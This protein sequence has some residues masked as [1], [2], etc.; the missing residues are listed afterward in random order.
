MRRLSLLAACLC[1]LTD[2]ASA[3]IQTW[4]VGDQAHPWILRVVTGR[5]DWGKPWAVE[6]L[7]DDDGD[8]LIDEDPVE[9]IDNDGDGL[10]NEDGPDPQVDNDGDGLFGEDPING[11]DDDGDGLVDEDP[12]E[13]IDWDLDGLVDEDASDC[14]AFP[15]IDPETCDEQ[16]D[17]DG[18]GLVNEDGLWTDG[19]D[20]YDNGKQNE[21]PAGDADGDGDP[22]DDGDG[23][24]D[25]DRP[26]AAHDDA[27]NV[28][29]WLSPVELLPNRNLAILMNERFLRGEFGGVP[30]DI[31][32]YEVIPRSPIYRVEPSD[33]FSASNWA[34][35]REISRTVFGPFIDGDLYTAFGTEDAGRG[36][37]YLKFFGTYW[38]HRVVFRTRPTVP[39][40]TIQ[41]Y[42]IRYGRPT[43]IHVQQQRIIAPR[44]IMP[45]VYSDGEPVKIIDFPEPVLAGRVDIIRRDSREYRRETAEVGVYGDG[46]PT[47]AIFTSAMIDVGVNPPR[48]RRYSQPIETLKASALASEFPDRPGSLVNWGTVRW[49]GRRVGREGDVRIQFRTGNSLNTHI[50]ARNLGGGIYDSFDKVGDPL[51]LASWIDPRR[52]NR[53]SEKDLRYNELGVDLGETDPDGAGGWS[54][55][56]APFKLEDGNIP[57]QVPQD[58]WKEYGVPLRVP[59]GTRYIQFRVLFDGTQ[60]SAALIDFIEF[61]YDA[62]LIRDGVIAEIYPSRVPMGEP[63]VFHYYVRPE[64]QRTERTTFNRLEIRVPGLDT[65]I[66]TFK[67]DEAPWEEIPALPGPGNDPLSGVTPARGQFAQATVLDSATG[68]PRLLLKTTQLGTADFQLGERLEIVF[69][70][71]L[72]RGSEEF[73]G[74]VWDDLT[75]D[76]DNSIAQPIRPGDVT[77]D[78]ATN[79]IVVVADEIGGGLEVRGVAP[80]PFTPNGDGV[81]D[82]VSFDLDVFLLLEKSDVRIDI[83]ELSGRVVRALQPG[84]QTAGH[85]RVTWDGLGDDGELVPPGIYIYRLTMGTD[86]TAQERTGTV[87]VAY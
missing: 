1:V 58:Q 76:P 84:Q 9:L 20:D 2:R 72:F 37:P 70:S 73:T 48:V 22:D 30:P 69:T 46:Y 74:V 6:V 21:D 85:L 24:V 39:K 53:V 71:A 59:G 41:D 81:N 51:T 28:T 25:E 5:L 38:I 7:V 55:W 78:V 75:Q 43:D 64:F 16:I 40:N 52:A 33:P 14:A 23:L 17:N 19:D 27:A 13:A 66:D 87:A 18:D 82:V 15:G 49:R 68:S 3:E 83:H 44:Q 63:S 56:S 47:D 34:E 61:E 42:D 86:Q 50:Y 67:V 65:R 4:R 77:A 29:T 45:R 60:H 79:G 36:G 62:A 8:G 31:Y 10:F 54:F 80:N 57:D 26:L 12:V 11:L 35:A 32:S